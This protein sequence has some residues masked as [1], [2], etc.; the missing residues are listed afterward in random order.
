MATTR[1]DIAIQVPQEA[2]DQ[3][4]KVKLS[5][6]QIQRMF[7]RSRNS[8]NPLEVLHEYAVDAG[9]TGVQDVMYSV[10]LDS[11]LQKALEKYAKL[12]TSYEP[13]TQAFENAVGMAMLNG[14]FVTVDSPNIN[15]KTLYLLES[16]VRHKLTKGTP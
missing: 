14:A 8:K 11:K 9:A 1:H 12:T 15:N 2:L 7:P 4:T 6:K 3:A 5:E 16:S 10:H 13:G